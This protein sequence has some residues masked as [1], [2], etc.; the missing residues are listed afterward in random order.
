MKVFTSLPAFF[1][2]ILPA[3]LLVSRSAIASLHHQS[4]CNIE[5]KKL[6]NYTEYCIKYCIHITIVGTYIIN[7]FIFRN[8]II[9]KAK[10]I[11][12]LTI[13]SFHI[14]QVNHFDD[15]NI[16]LT[17]KKVLNVPFTS[18]FCSVVNLPVIIHCF[19]G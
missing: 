7:N 4:S 13:N 18:Y 1:S 3:C 12:I 6:R 5:L 11:N 10:I 9:T 14:R 15:I 17:Y 8:I 16:S 2:A 19:G